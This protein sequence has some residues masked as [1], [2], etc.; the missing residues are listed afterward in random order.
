MRISGRTASLRFVVIAPF[1]AMLLLS[2]ALVVAVTL[3]SQ[4]LIAADYSARLL[5]SETENVRSRLMGF[6]SE[7]FR[8]CK[9]AADAIGRGG[10]QASGRF[11]EAEAYLRSDLAT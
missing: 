10:V 4:G 7:P 11:A 6:L 2:V 8:A 5:S 9:A 3:R 1:A